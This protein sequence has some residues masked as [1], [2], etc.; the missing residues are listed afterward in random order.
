[1]PNP[2]ASHRSTD[3]CRRTDGRQRIPSTSAAKTMRSITVPPGPTSSNRVVAIADPNWTAPI[4]TR[5]STVGGIDSARRLVLVLER[6]V[7]ERVH[8]AQV[9]AAGLERRAPL[10]VCQLRATLG[11]G[12]LDDRLGAAALLEV[13]H[14]SRCFVST[15]VTGSPV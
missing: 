11:T 7:L 15:C 13:R 12:L 9:G 5:T 3:E 14:Q 10:G 1:M 8:L 6:D 4:P 2:A